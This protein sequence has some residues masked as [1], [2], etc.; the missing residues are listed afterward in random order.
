TPLASDNLSDIANAAKL[1]PFAADDAA[2]AAEVTSSAQPAAY[3]ISGSRP[4][5]GELLHDA[6][7]A[8][9][10]AEQIE[11]NQVRSVERRLE[12]GRRLDVFFP[13]HRQ[14]MEWGKQ[15]LTVTVVE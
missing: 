5:A 3:K 11:P 9:E 4:G 7:P 13:T 2:G 1:D 10:Q 8:A 15:W 14:A 12:Q 6:A